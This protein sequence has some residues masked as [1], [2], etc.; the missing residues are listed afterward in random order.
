MIFDELK[1]WKHAVIDYQPNVTD[2]NNVVIIPTMFGELETTADE[3]QV[4]KNVRK[5]IRKRGMSVRLQDCELFPNNE[6]NNNGD[7]FH[8]ALMDEFEPVKMEEV[9]E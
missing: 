4:E 3:V 7:L 1:D 9:F 6:V 5:S 2:Y 8:F